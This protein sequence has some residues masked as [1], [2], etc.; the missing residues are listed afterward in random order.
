[1]RTPP[2]QQSERRDTNERNTKS[3]RQDAQPAPSKS[4]AEAAQANTNQV[5][6]YPADSGGIS[7]PDAIVA[8]FTVIL[9]VV[10]ILQILL[11]RRQHVAMFRPMVKVRTVAY[12]SPDDTS[13]IEIVLA[14]SGSTD[15]KIVEGRIATVLRQAEQTIVAHP[16]AGVPDSFVTPSKIPA[17]HTTLLVWLN[18]RAAEHHQNVIPVLMRDQRLWL[19][20]YVAYADEYGVRRKTGFCRMLE[21]GTQRFR[22]V[23]DPDYEYAD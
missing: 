18:P 1:M 9:G 17:G 8:M 12:A 11:M 5:N 6:N 3:E 13:P 23:E 14:N 22:I 21:A 16:F 19:V 2:K 4:A 7:V 15:A 10:A 20:G